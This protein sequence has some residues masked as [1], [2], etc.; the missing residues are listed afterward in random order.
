M[1]GNTAF[2]DAIKSAVKD[3]ALL[4]A[5]NSRNYLES[6]YCQDELAWFHDDNSERPGGLK[7]GDELRIFNILL[8]NIPHAEWPE[9]LGETGGFCMHDARDKELGDFYGIIEDDCQT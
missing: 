6:A 7:V 3:S 5:L 1:Q 9:A 8:N 4:F 2:N